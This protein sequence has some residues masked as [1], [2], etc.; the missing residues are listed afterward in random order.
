MRAMSFVVVPLS[1]VSSNP[2]PTPVAALLQF[3]A[4]IG[5]GLIVTWAEH[6][7]GE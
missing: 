2:K 6:L 4:M 1:A 5:F 7:A 3:I